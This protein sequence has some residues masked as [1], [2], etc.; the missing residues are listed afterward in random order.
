ME[1]QE[2]KTLEL[3]LFCDTPCKDKDTHICLVCPNLYT[4]W[5]EVKE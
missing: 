1:N 5:N 2:E 3:R 4:E